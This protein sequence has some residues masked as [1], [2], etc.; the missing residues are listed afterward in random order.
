MREIFALPVRRSFWESGTKEEKWR[1]MGVFRLFACYSTGVP[2][3]GCRF[4]GALYLTTSPRVKTLGCS[5]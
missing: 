1:P 2:N 3:I 4:Q 5:V